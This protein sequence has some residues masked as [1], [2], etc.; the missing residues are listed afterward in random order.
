MESYVCPITEEQAQQLVANYKTKKSKKEEE[1]NKLL[2]ELENS[3]LEKLKKAKET[4]EKQEISRR[5][6]PC[7]C[8]NKECTLDIIIEYILPSGEIVEERHHS[9]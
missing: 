8:K 1:Y 7:N 2:S 5:I 9:Y 6:V 4:N 3:R